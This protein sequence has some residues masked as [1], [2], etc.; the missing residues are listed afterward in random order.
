MPLGHNLKLSLLILRG[1][2]KSLGRSV[3]RVRTFGLCFILDKVRRL[4]SSCHPHLSHYYV[5]RSGCGDV[6][7]GILSCAPTA[8]TKVVQNHWTPFK[9]MLHS[10]LVYPRSDVAMPGNT[11]NPAWNQEDNVD[12][13][14]FHADSGEQVEKWTLNKWQGTLPV[15]ANDSLWD[16]RGLQIQ[17]GQNQ[18]FSYYFVIVE[19]GQAI[20]Q[21][22]PTQATFT[23]IRECL[24]RPI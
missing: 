11:G 8:D 22:E 7:N 1:K 2:S 6:S 21:G 18:S 17:T 16:A 12:I 9:C 5:P 13:Y 15:Q 23:A 14:L 24:S 4:I 3:K 10:G 19:Q 20:H